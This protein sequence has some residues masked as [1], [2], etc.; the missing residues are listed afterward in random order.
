MAPLT[1]S[2]VLTSWTA[3][4][5]VL[6][7]AAVLVGGYLVGRRRIVTGPGSGAW[8]VARTTSF[9]VG[10]ALIVLMGTSFVAVYDDTLFWTRALQGVILLVVAPMLLAAGAPLTVA[11]EVLPGR[12][13]ALLGRVRRSRPA[14]ILT[15][16]PVV[17]LLLVAPPFLIY[18]TP[19]YAEMLRNK[20]V[21]G[22]VDVVLLT[23]GFVY[24]A[25]RLRVDPVPRQDSYAVTLAISVVEVISDGV[26]GLV[27]WLGPLIAVSHYAALARTWGPDLR[28]DQV[29][30]A[31]IWW[32]GGDLAGIPFLAAITRRMQLEDNDKAA[33]ID[34]AL[35]AEGAE[36]AA[37]GGEAAADAAST[38]AQSDAPAKL[39]W[40]DNPE[41]AQRFRRR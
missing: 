8:P 10:V 28:T 3:N 11:R 38:D 39:W 35:D 21:S 2:D 20:V 19:L 23:A 1:P 7:A 5:V 36:R 18:L 37:A 24:V 40:E 27:L 32:I 13:R 30:G 4:P 14:R 29:I 12:I 25:S 9:M 6:L 31:G 41:L 34:A 26:L 22:V 15:L 16:P 33:A 17:T